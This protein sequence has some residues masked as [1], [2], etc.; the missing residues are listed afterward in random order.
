MVA[1]AVYR[2]VVI[3]LDPG[4]GKICWAN[5]HRDSDALGSI[6]CADLDGSKVEEIQVGGRTPRA[7]AL[8]TAAGRIYWH[9]GYDGTIRRAGLDG[10]NVEELINTRSETVALALDTVG[11]KIYWTD[12]SSYKILRADLDGSRQEE[13]VGHQMG[14]LSPVGLALDLE[15]RKM[16][17]TN[18]YVIRRAGLDG[19]H[20]EDVIVVER[21]ATICL[22]PIA[23][24]VAR[25][26]IY[27]A[28]TEDEISVI[29]RANLDGSDV[30]DFVSI[31]FPSWPCAI[32]LDF[33]APVPAALDI[34]PGSCPNP[35]NIRS[36]GVVPAA[37]TG[38]GSFDAAEIDVD[39]LVLKRT[40]GVG[41]SLAPIRRRS[42]RIGAVEDVTTPF[43]AE[44]CECH[45]LAGDGYD[46]LLIKFS[47]LE[48]TRILELG[49]EA[50]G[51]PVM[52]TV[53][54]STLDG[55][56]FVASDCILLI[57]SRA[58]P[59]SGDLIHGGAKH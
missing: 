48:M 27:W 1:T 17:W 9:D 53:S 16:Y 7:F 22:P 33:R 46:D 28:V 2:P 3:T 51:S 40:D 35:V 29:R 26:H 11:G 37:I 31:P 20:L 12:F 54:G 49:S 13:L 38:T 39:S 56:P 34:R 30:E 18:G 47:T 55:T 4:A 24:D 32:A 14:L 50:P 41:G 23:L 19:A 15:A 57:G 45:E 58:S 36:R 52:L 5:G 8:D 25:G 43:D 59:R 42:G 10:S 21:R 6:F 44:P